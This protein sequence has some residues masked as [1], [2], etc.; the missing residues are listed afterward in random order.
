MLFRSGDRLVVWLANLTVAP[1]ALRV[2]G[3]ANPEPRL[4]V[5]DAES[6]EQAVR[7][8]DAL[9]NLARPFPGEQ[10]QLDAYAVARID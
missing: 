8:P 3:L 5:I 9:E 6:F 7:D 2:T 4:S 10:I 1:L